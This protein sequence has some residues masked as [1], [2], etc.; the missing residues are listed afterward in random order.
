MILFDA[1]RKL[2]RTKES[3]DEA[4]PRSIVMLLRSP[5]TMSQEILEVAATKAYG[6]PYDGSHKMY[7]VSWSP[8]LTGVKAGASLISVLEAAEPYLGDPAKVAQGFKDK[9]LRSAWSEHHA[10]TAFDLMNKNTS[11]R[12]AYQVLAALVAELLDARC[13]GIYLPRENQFTIQ[14]DGSAAEHLRRLAR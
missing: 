4:A 5:F 7:F 11:D 2:L 3:G 9:R 13:S 12:E 1:F 14:S 8:P 6:I 10:W